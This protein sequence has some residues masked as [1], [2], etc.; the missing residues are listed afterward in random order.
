M[1]TCDLNSGV[2]QLTLAYAQ[3]K[4]QWAETQAQW[5]DENMRQFQEQHLQEIPGRLQWL[6][7]AAQ[8]LAEV[9]DKAERDLNDHA[10]E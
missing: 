8:R 1:R 4:Q 3:L 7:A 10:A 2:G 5:T 6:V 9:V